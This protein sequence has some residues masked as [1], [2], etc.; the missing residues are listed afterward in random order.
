MFGLKRT[1]VLEWCMV[2]WELKN[3]HQTNICWTK[4]GL[5]VEHLFII[6]DAIVHTNKG[7]NLS[8]QF[9]NS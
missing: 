9:D 3:G 4:I 6:L 7:R 2:G 8:D 1:H 5:Y